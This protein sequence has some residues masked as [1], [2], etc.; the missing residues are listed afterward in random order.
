L[1]SLPRFL[2][3]SVL[4]VFYALAPVTAM[5]AQAPPAGPAPASEELPRFTLRQIV[6]G[7]SP[8]QWRI[9]GP[10]LRAAIDVPPESLAAQAY[11]A[12]AG[13]IGI[14]PL[15]GRVLTAERSP[16]VMGLF[17]RAELRA[18]SIRTLEGIRAGLSSDSVRARFDG[19]FRRRGQWIVDLHDAALAWARTRSPGM[20]WESARAALVGA[21][22]LAADERDPEA[23][24]LPRALYG[25]AVL[26]GT[27][28]AAFAAARASLWRA[29]SSSAAAALLL[30]N[31]Y[32]EGQRWYAD[33]L[34]F[35]LRE[36]WVPESGG[37]SIQDYVLE[38]WALTDTTGF[39]PSLP[40]IQTRWF[41]YPQAVPQYGVPEVLFQHLLHLENPAAAEWFQQHERGDLLRT[42]R[43]L[44]VGDTNLALLRTATETL[45]LST[46][47]R[48][49][50]ESLNG[51]LEPEDAI[52]IDP[53]YS[54]LLALGA[55]VHEWQHLLFRRRQLER[56]GESLAES[57][58]VGGVRL[59]GVQPHLAEGFAEWSSE[60]ILHPI[61]ERWPLL[62]LGELEKRADLTQHS[63][64]DQH[65]LG[66]ALVRALA[67]ALHNPGRTIET[68]LR[69][70]EDL[71]LIPKEPALRRAWIRY[72]GAPDRQLRSQALPVLIPEV[73]FTID[74]GFPD[75]V[76]TRIL[77]PSKDAARH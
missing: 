77:V 73:T 39:A 50:R 19:L 3:G 9:P 42:L 5:E 43:W 61:T 6:L 7:R 4:F 55:V 10:W 54:P 30:L 31:G 35:F 17:R 33:A 23:E 47:S 13:R 66:Y 40:R 38:E 22:W 12:A 59:P 65:A 60:R 20:A 25:L 53:G 8:S 29:D 15:E 70:P 57:D 2:S 24:A 51:F 72:R 36:R 16:H 32:T 63:S 68:L 37:R 1:P 76:A 75:V 69:H 71:A 46:V 56:F 62:A 34:G 67:T 48:Q 58:L 11:H 18:A 21:H 27:D 14:E 52:V 49:S 44:P 26:A 45:R 74:D 64:D 41:G 28:S